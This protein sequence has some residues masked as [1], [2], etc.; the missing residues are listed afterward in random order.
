MIKEN[1]MCGDSKDD[2]LSNRYQKNIWEKAN[3]EFLCNFYFSVI[4]K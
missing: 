1:T 2:K 4:L 3:G